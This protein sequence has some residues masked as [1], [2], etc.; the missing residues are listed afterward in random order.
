M[1]YTQCQ[2]WILDHTDISIKFIFIL[3]EWD[4]LVYAAF[5]RWPTIQSYVLF[6][7][8]WY[9]IMSLLSGKFWKLYNEIQR[10]SVVLVLFNVARSV[11]QHVN[12]VRND[13]L[14]I[15]SAAMSLSKQGEATSVCGHHSASPDWWIPNEITNP[16]FSYPIKWEKPC[17]TVNI[18]NILVL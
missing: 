11:T 10:V 4:L 2:L 5:S 18:L 7:Y 3:M 6:S 15:N 8:I 16:T 17:Y 12:P 9:D 14:C 1:R 13:Y